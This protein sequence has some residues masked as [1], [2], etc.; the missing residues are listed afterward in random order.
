MLALKGDLLR[1]AD[2]WLESLG[3]HVVC[4]GHAR[5]DFCS[6]LTRGWMAILYTQLQKCQSQEENK[7]LARRGPVEDFS[8][9]YAALSLILLI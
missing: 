9:E 7:F 4:Q 5:A 1:A 8:L 6:N 3:V 2:P